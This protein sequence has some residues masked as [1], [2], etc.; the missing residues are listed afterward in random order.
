MENK[1][2]IIL[3]L[4]FLSLF[5]CIYFIQDTYA[6]YLTKASTDVTG[7]VAR[8]NIEVNDTVIKNNSTLTNLITPNFSGTTHIAPNVIAPTVTGSFELEIDSTN[9]DV[10]YTYTI[11]IERNED[12]SDFIVT[13][14]KVDNGSIINVDTSV[15][16]PSITNDVLLSDT[17][18]VHTITVYIGWND[19]ETTQ[20]MD[21]Q[22]DTEVTVDLTDVT[23][24][25][26]MNFVQKAT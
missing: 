2:K 8:W 26:L 21:N 13:G 24:S 20:N 3:L 22:E 14:Y 7:R 16:T 10:S 12:L 9:V 6:K 18:R 4:A 15:E 25:V 19:N 23:L 1:N 11:S 17:Q 5:T